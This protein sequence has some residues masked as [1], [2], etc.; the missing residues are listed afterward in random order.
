M[1]LDP[2]IE[3]IFKSLEILSPITQDH[4]IKQFIEKHKEA[5]KDIS[6]EVSK[7]ALGPL[8]YAE[9]VS[10]ARIPRSITP[11]SIKTTSKYILNSTETPYHRD[12]RKV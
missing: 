4:I 8:T 11:D 1:S 5:N 7:E 6:K 3:E 9:V 10:G 12:S 2:Q